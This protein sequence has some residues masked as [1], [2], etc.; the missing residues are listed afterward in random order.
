ML[1]FSNLQHLGENLGHEGQ[2]T[3][4]DILQPCNIP[5][6][7][8]LGHVVS[9]KKIF[10]HFLYIYAYVKHLTPGAGHFWS[11]GYNL[12]KVGRGLLGEATY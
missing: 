1:Y 8:A 6:I 5:N 2:V 12:S 11:L 4:L 9:D 10:S 7:K 3:N